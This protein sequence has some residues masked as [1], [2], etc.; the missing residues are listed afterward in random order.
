M[1][2]LDSI[3]ERVNKRADE[4]FVCTPNEDYKMAFVRHY[5]LGA[6]EQR[7]IDIEKACEWLRWIMENGSSYGAFPNKQ[8]I[9]DFRKYMEE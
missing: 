9:E 6:T 3:I 2:E 1:K 8:S 4:I 5:A 7:Q